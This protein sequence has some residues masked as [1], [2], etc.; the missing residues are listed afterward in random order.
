[1]RTTNLLLLITA[2]SFILLSSAASF[3][4]SEPRANTDQ[5]TAQ[6]IISFEPY[7]GPGY[8]SM[9]VQVLSMKGGFEQSEKNVFVLTE[10]LV[11]NKSDKTVTGDAT[12]SLFVFKDNEPD[13]IVKQAFWTVIN[14]SAIDL[15][16]GKKF[17][18]QPITG[19]L[20]WPQLKPIKRLLTENSAKEHYRIAI[21]ITKVHFADGSVWQFTAPEQSKKLTDQ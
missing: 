15:Q 7:R 18:M 20:L 19:Q 21:A 5:A 8:E 12:F 9:P 3:A 4:Q 6:E 16:A 14:F 1:M 13:T 17:S 11:Q 10:V 2:F